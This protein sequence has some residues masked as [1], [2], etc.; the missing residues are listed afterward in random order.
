MKTF[1]CYD[2]PLQLSGLNYVH[3]ETSDYWRLSPEIIQQMPQ[4]KDLGRRCVGAR[5][6]F[7]TDSRKITI[8]YT[9]KTEA[10]DRAMALPAA[11]GVDMYLGTG[12]DAQYIGYIAPA[13][14]QYKN[15]IIEG[16]VEK[17]DS[18]ELV[19]INL[20]RNELLASLE[21]CVE[22]HCTVLPP[23]SYTFKDPIIFYG[24]S[25][26]EGGCAPRPGTAYTS[27]VSRWLDADY[28]NYGFSGGAKGEE[29]FAHFIASHKDIGV[30]VYD[31][32]HNAPD[33]EHLQNTHNNFFQ[34]IRKAHPLLPVVMMSRPDFGA[35]S[36][37]G[38][39][40]RS[41]IYNTYQNAMQAGDN[42]VYF[43]DGNTMFGLLG[44]EEC[45]IDRCHPTGLGFMRM[46]ESVYQLLRTIL[47]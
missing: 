40:R 31:Y 29:E 39:Q 19:T 14:Y 1:Q 7:Q 17:S 41:I 15:S 20:P 37:D 25:I 32:D 2:A 22:D 24:S 10:V 44:R 47:I 4:Y 16:T 36:Q 33:A 13:A 34:I 26:T 18:M 3:P 5:L 45:T 11:V 35:N 43:I 46:A 30:F 28:Y 42:H 12:L 9:V 6:R 8:R 38:I 23:P 27:I 21:V